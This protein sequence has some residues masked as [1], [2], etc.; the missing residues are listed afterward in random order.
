MFFDT[1]N[2]ISIGTGANVTIASSA[3]IM[4]ISMKDPMMVVKVMNISSGAWW[5]NSD[6]SF[7]SLTI[8]EIIFP[9]FTLSK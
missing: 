3:F 6:I 1:V 8:L 2:H 9:F 5:A 4:N 7:R